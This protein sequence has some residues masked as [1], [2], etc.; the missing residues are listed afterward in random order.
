MPF[1]NIYLTDRAYGG[2]EEG[3]WWYGCGE[4]ERVI[5]VTT[6]RRAERAMRLVQRVMDARN[7]DRCSDVSSVLSEGCYVACIERTPGADYPETRPRYE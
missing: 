4:L 6:H 5:P 2:P 1:I 7:A 3:G